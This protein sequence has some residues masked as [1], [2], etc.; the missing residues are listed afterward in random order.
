MT[1]STENV[2]FAATFARAKAL[3]EPAFNSR[4]GESDY[5][6][7]LIELQFCACLHASCRGIIGETK[8]YSRASH[9]A[10]LHECLEVPVN[11]SVKEMITHL[12][13]SLAHSVEALQKLKIGNFDF[14]RFSNDY[15]SFSLDKSWTVACCGP[16][17]LT[18]APCQTQWPRINELAREQRQES[19]QRGR[20][21][22]KRHFATTMR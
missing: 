12:S 13:A 1:L 8:K 15:A 9:T 17:A 21:D 5:G 11:C 7:G 2:E 6:S 19:T 16:A 10:R 22:Q 14:E 4:F 18:G 20:G 3:M